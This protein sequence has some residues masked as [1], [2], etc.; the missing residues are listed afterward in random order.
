M[1]PLQVMAQELNLVC[2]YIFS[3]LQ[4][5]KKKKKKSQYFKI[6]G[7]LCK[8]IKI[9]ET[10]KIGTSL[11]NYDIEAARV[12]S[13]SLGF[14]RAPLS[15]APKPLSVAAARPK[16]RTSGVRPHHLQALPLF[17]ATAWLLGVCDHSF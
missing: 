14:H 12:S 1:K 15:P 4:C 11:S 16:Q 8:N 5:P 13:L 3:D 7:N 17:M 2:S 6:W 9:G 10:R